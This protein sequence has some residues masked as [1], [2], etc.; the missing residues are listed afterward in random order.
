MTS[1]EA[2]TEELKRRLRD[3]AAIKGHADVAEYMRANQVG[4]HVPNNN[5][6][7]TYST[8]CLS[9]YK[10][11]EIHVRVRVLLMNAT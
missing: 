3:V 1:L 4:S 7:R 9:T 6:L 5:T 2:E 11:R 8:V 10:K